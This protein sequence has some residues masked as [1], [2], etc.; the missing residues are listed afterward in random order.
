M[1]Q[2]AVLVLHVGVPGPG[3]GLGVPGPG[4]GLIFSL[5]VKVRDLSPSY[6]YSYTSAYNTCTPARTYLY[7][8]IHVHLCTPVMAGGHH[9]QS[10]LAYVKHI[11]RVFCSESTVISCLHKVW[12]TSPNAATH[13][14]GLIITE[15][16]SS[17]VC[18]RAVDFT[19][20]LGSLVGRAMHRGRWT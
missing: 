15:K 8:P 2:L 11:L 17:L 18:R 1:T 5:F 10:F 14:R 3:F 13:V 16:R 9:V 6:W 7:S 19:E 20:E 12:A 4:F